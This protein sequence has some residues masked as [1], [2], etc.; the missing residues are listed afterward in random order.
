MRRRVVGYLRL[1]VWGTVAVLV[2]VFWL[3]VVLMAVALLIR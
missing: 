2:V 3:L 1:L